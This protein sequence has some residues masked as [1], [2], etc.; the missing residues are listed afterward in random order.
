M[1]H[2]NKLRE[3]LGYYNQN[4]G[5]VIKLTT[6]QKQHQRKENKLGRAKYLRSVKN[7]T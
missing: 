1:D 5:G 3:K 4:T 2:L 6:R 7:I